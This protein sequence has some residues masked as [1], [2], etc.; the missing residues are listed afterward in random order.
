MNSWEVYFY[1]LDILNEAPIINLVKRV[2]KM[3][4]VLK[5]KYWNIENLEFHVLN[6]L[7]SHLLNKLANVWKLS[8]N[9]IRNDDKLTNQISDNKNEMK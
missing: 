5:W 2:K 3:F 4:Y 1:A 9:D 7:I 6:K 8:E